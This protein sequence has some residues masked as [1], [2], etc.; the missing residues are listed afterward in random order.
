[1]QEKLYLIKLAG[2]LPIIREQLGWTQ[3]ELAR[4]L[5]LSRANIVSVE[6]YP[7][8]IGK[9]TALALFTAV[10]GELSLKKSQYDSLDFSLWDAD[11]AENRKTLLK[12]M[13]SIAWGRKKLA[14]ALVI[15]PIKDPLA[16]KTVHLINLLNNPESASESSPLSK[17]DIQLILNSSMQHIEESICECLGLEKPD[18][19][20]YLNNLED[21]VYHFSNLEIEFSIGNISAQDDIAIIVNAT[22]KHLS[23]SGGGDRAVH[24]AAGR[25]LDKE[26]KAL[27]PIEI[28]QAVATKAYGLPNHLIIHCAGPRFSVD[29]PAPELLAGCYRNALLLADEYAQKNGWTSIAFPSIST[30]S[31][32]YPVKQAAQVVL[33][34]LLASQPDLMTIKKIRFVLFDSHTLNVYTK[35]WDLL[36]RQQQ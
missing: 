26:C 27:S 23:G 15:G 18:V 2:Q 29:S 25:Q 17:E 10:F 35:T 12:Q 21:I 36:T 20:R 33:E 1:M 30:G 8:K 9:T 19:G 7:N 28:G 14:S 32:G 24:R 13:N 4:R 6:Q 22:D 34:T 3:E 11:N 16:N 5:G 31:F